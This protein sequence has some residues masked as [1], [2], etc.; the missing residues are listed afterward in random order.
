MIRAPREK[1]A[2]KLFS[3]IITSFPI[4]HTGIIS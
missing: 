4:P 1:L 3:A 2:R